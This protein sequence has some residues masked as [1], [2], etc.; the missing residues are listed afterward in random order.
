[1]AAAA[2]HR[3]V[4]ADDSALMRRILS[5]TLEDQGFEVVG[6]ARDGDEALALCERHRPDAMTLDL[7]MPGTDGIAVLRAL[8]RDAAPETPV[9]VVS[10]FSPAHGARAV[11]A[12]AEGAFDLVAKPTP[13][14]PPEQFGSQLRTKLR[15]AA[16]SVRGRRVARGATR[17]VPARPRTGGRPRAVLIA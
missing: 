17:A 10:A 1:M 6:E 16:A 5:R 14:Q 2:P 3:V 11:D 9:V 13:G 12:L 7:A 4:V 8:R 15:A